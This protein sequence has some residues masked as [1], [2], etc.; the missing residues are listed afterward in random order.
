MSLA[1]LPA[2][3]SRPTLTASVSSRGQAAVALAE[4]GTAGSSTRIRVRPPAAV[5]CKHRSGRMVLH[6]WTAQGPGLRLVCPLSPRP[7][8][9]VPELNRGRL[10]AGGDHGPP[11]WPWGPQAAPRAPPVPLRPC[12]TSRPLARKSRRTF[13]PVQRYV[14]GIL[15]TLLTKQDVYFLFLWQILTLLF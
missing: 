5:P 8:G 14:L 10:A 12:C 6:V 9:S 7:K 15:R 4:S 3:S 1:S 13:L 2:T 11:A